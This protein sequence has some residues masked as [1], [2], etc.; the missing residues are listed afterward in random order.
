MKKIEAYVDGS[1]REGLVGW[2]AVIVK[3]DALYGELSG[4]LNEEEVQGT[5]QV[6]GELKA[7]K[8][9]IFWCKEQKVKEISI[10]YDY[11]G[12]KEWVTG[13][14]K[15]KKSVTQDYRDYV[16]ASGVN[17][18]WVKVK[19]H[20]GNRYNDKADKLAREIIGG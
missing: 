14:W 2:G 18:Y 20:S 8:E 12:I 1:Y 17:I 4:I 15:A 13:T 7:V 9:V 5:R 11:T 16:R 6:A 10:Y 19:S 3:D